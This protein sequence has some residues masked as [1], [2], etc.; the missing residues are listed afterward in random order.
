M[1]LPKVFGDVEAFVRYR[2]QLMERA[3]QKLTF[4]RGAVEDLCQI[5]DYSGVPLFFQKYEIKPAVH[6][7]SKVFG[8]HYPETKG[9]TMFVN[10]PA[11]FANLW[12]AFTLVL[13]K[14]TLQKFVIL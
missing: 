14:R 10:F 9:V 11:A 12:K 7:I 2:A 5:H 4:E 3:V 13:D 8:E 6:A 1:D